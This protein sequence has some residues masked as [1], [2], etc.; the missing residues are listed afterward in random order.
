MGNSSP[1]CP[2]DCNINFVNAT[3]QYC[4]VKSEYNGN[5]SNRCFCCPIKS[6]C[7]FLDIERDCSQYRDPDSLYIFLIIVLSILVLICCFCIYPWIQRCCQ[8]QKRR[9]YNNLNPEPL[10]LPINEPRV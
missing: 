3:Q 7:D 6:S 2:R 1:P 5:V 10:L 4:Y 8:R 9:L